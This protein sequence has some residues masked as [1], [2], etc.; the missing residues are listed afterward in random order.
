M[1]ALTKRQ[2]EY[3]Q[4]V[5]D[6]ANQSDAYRAAYNT[7]GMLAKTVWE[8]ASRLRKHPKV[9][10]RIDQLQEEKEAVRRMLYVVRIFGTISHLN[11]ENI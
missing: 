4:L 11:A 3:A 9:V 2:S 6:G 7:S 5:S 10:A 1:Q 8:D